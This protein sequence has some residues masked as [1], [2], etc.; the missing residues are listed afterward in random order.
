MM[1]EDA[2]DLQALIAAAGAGDRNSLAR[3]LE[4]YRARLEALVILRLD[5]RLQR[6]IDAADVVQE[7]YLALHDKFE[8]WRARQKLPFYLWLRLEVGQKLADLHRY[9]L[10][11]RMRDAAQ[12]VSLHS[13]GMPSIDSITL[14]ERFVGHL[15]SPSHG[16]I[17]AE[18]VV[19]VQDALNEM[20]ASDREVLVLRHFEDLNNAECAVVLDIST[21]AASNRYVRALK[22]LKQAFAKQPGGIEGVW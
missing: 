16:A 19:R 18:L 1:S 6:R 10:G 3:L 7:T 11:A 8:R 14:A 12:E 21:T 9:H 17:R 2:S 13:G 4:L 22:R 5:R 20:D 15:S